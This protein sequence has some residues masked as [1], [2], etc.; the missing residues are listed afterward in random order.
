MYDYG[1]SPQEAQMHLI[2]SRRMRSSRSSLV[3]RS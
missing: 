2:S 3:S 1:S